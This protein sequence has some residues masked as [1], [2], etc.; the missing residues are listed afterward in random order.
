M[1]D[2]VLGL[3][4]TVELGD[5]RKLLERNRDEEEEALKKLRSELERLAGELR[6]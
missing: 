6:G 3:A 1:Y 4:A 5:A 2:A